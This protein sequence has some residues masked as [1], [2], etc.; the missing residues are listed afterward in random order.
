MPFSGF[1]SFRRAAKCGPSPYAKE[2]ADGRKVQKRCHGLGLVRLC[3]SSPP[4]RC[5]PPLPF[6]SHKSLPRI[7][8]LIRGRGRDRSC[9]GLRASGS[10][11]RPQRIRV[12]RSFVGPRRAG[13]QPRLARRPRPSRRVLA[14]LGQL[15]DQRRHPSCG[16]PRARPQPLNRVRNLALCSHCPGCGVLHAAGPR[17]RREAKRSRAFGPRGVF[18]TTVRMRFVRETLSLPKRAAALS[19][20]AKT[21]HPS[22]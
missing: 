14:R 1:S 20:R 4:R 9:R 13:P 19:V 11:R 2:T 6:C 7:P 10:R 5:F 12:N 22:L 17:R 18:A 15:R 21:S 16:L 3:G 8:S